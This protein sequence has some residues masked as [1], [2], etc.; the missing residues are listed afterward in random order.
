MD[1]LICNKK[2]IDYVKE[3]YPS[4]LNV[5]KANRSY[6]QANHL[7][8]TFIT[9][10]NKLSTK[11]D[12]KCDDFNFHNVNFPSCQVMCYLA[13]H[14]VCTFHSSSDIRLAPSPSLRTAK[15]YVRLKYYVKRP[16]CI[17]D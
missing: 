8:L 13:P 16:T 15:V 14:I 4:E 9:G 6:D 10:N 1:D 7:D 3:I 2:F 11:L 5:E 12:D 17:G